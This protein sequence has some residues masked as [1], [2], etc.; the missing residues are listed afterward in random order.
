MPQPAEVVYEL[1]SLLLLFTIILGIRLV[2]LLPMERGGLLVITALFLCMLVWEH[3]FVLNTKSSPA[4][5]AGAYSA[6]SPCISGEKTWN[7]E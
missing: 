6:A 1:Q 7:Q 3:A 2:L 5:T 4:G